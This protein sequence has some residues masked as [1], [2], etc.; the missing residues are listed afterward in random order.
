MVA[1]AGARH[2]VGRIAAIALGTSLG[3]LGLVL[4][5][6]VAGGPGAID[7]SQA[8]AVVTE[9]PAEIRGF[10]AELIDEEKPTD[11]GFSWWTAWRLCWDS[12]P[13]VVEWLVT[14]VSFEGAGEP[15]AVT[16]PCYEIGVASGT[17][18]E[19]GSYPGRSEQLIQVEISMSIS[20]AARMA[21]GSVGPASPD[22]PV[23][24]AVP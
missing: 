13:G 3:G 21:D 14:T 24:R 12:D 7:S 11:T 20:V 9:A 6:R 18:R 19:S 8:P 10:H 15:R 22:I 16:E 4:S 23:G 17:S 2:G 1:A 5:P